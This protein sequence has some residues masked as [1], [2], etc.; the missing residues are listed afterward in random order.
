MWPIGPLMREHRL[1]ER[2]I[3][4]MEDKADGLRSG[5]PG[6]PDLVKQVVDFFRDYADLCHHGKE[7]DILFSELD[8]RGLTPELQTIMEQLVREH[9]QGREMVGRLEEANQRF[10]NGDKGALQ[11][12]ADLLDKLTAFYPKHIAKED[13]EFF[14]PCM[15]LFSK[16]EK[17]AMLEKFWEFDRQLIHE[18]NEK[19]VS[20]LEEK[21]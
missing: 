1:I 12:V 13:E 9:V 8:E 2:L 7:E 14:Y 17:D 15:E 18:L 11:E 10:E 5:Q 21:A 6:D 20:A 19:L 16:E 4:V 3:K